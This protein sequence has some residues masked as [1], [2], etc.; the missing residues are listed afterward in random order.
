[1][2]LLSFIRVKK[3][4]SRGKQCH[5]ETM[6]SGEALRLSASIITQHVPLRQNTEE[7][8]RGKVLEEVWSDEDE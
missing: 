7:K 4:E 6:L 2:C 8:V 3:G 1:M 5:A